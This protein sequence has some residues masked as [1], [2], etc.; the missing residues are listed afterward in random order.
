[1]PTRHA[2]ATWEGGFQNGKGSFQG[3]SNAI[4]GSYSAG[5]RFGEAGG[6]NPEEL[7]AAAQAAC[8]SMAFA[9]GLDKNGTPAERVHT[10]AACTIEKQGEGFTITTM[11]LKTRA[12]VPGLDEAKFQELAEAAR[13]GCPVARALTGVRIELDAALES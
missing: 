10:E 5:S 6:T 1:M 12:R 9:L 7:L 3:E 11:K 13:T 4:H 8:F 2:S